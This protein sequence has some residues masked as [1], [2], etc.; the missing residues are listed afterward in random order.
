MAYPL[1]TYVGFKLLRTVGRWQRVARSPDCHKAG[2][3]HYG[4]SC[5][6][7]QCHQIGATLGHE[8]HYHRPGRLRHEGWP[9]V[10]P[11]EP[12]VPSSAAAPSLP[13]LAGQP[14]TNV[15]GRRNGEPVPRRPSARFPLQHADASAADGSPVLAMAG[16]WDDWKNVET[17]ERLLACTMLITE[18]NNFVAEVYD[19]MPVILRP[20]S[21]VHGRE[22]GPM[23]M[24]A[25]LEDAL[26]LGHRSLVRSL[27]FS[28]RRCA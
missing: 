5:H 8:S 1:L 2:E 17:K 21:A 18:P 6:K 22:R 13:D 20:S 7:R 4:D 28:A 12:P 26:T 9:S 15:T 10:T 16:L 24:T 3:R 27:R 14:G 19:R 11:D 23:P 25:I